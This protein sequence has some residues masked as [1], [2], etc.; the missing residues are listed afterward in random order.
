[1]RGLRG[2]GLLVAGLLL[3]GCG[4]GDPAAP[5]SASTTT[6]R[7]TSDTVFLTHV[8]D[9]VN[10]GA[11]ADLISQGKDACHAMTDGGGTRLDAASRLVS[12]GF[13]T[14][15]AAAIVTAAV[16]AYCPSVPE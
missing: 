5:A 14:A 15:D 16:E 1:M 3:A 6:G 11:D 9:T 13:D 10:G 4:G 8:R 7:S 12:S 2:W